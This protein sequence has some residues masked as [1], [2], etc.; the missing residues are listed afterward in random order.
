MPFRCRQSHNSTTGKRQQVTEVRKNVKPEIPSLFLPYCSNAPSWFSIQKAHE[1][2]KEKNPQI[3][4]FHDL[5]RQKHT[6][7]E[8][9]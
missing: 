4:F 3:S 8:N 6:T 1:R 5:H 7:I 9:R 2:K